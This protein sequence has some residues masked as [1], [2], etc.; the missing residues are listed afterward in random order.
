MWKILSNF[1][2]D[3]HG[4]FAEHSGYAYVWQLNEV[5]ICGNENQGEKL[6]VLVT[7]LSKYNTI[8]SRNCH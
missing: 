3:K 4:N 5:G 8:F 1:F 6:L 7:K 2:N